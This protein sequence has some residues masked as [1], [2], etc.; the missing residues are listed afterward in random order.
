MKNL[1]SV[2]FLLRSYMESSCKNSHSVIQYYKGTDPDTQ[3]VKISNSLNSSNSVDD[4]LKE[5]LCHNSEDKLNKNDTD[6]T[7]EQDGFKGETSVTCNTDIIKTEKADIKVEP[8]SPNDSNK[9]IKIE[10]DFNSDESGFTKM[11]VDTKSEACFGDDSLKLENTFNNDVIDDKKEDLSVTTELLE[12]SS[13]E[14][15]QLTRGRK[16][17]LSS[18]TLDAEPTSATNTEE[19]EGNDESMES[20]FDGNEETDKPRKRGRKKGKKSNESIPAHLSSDMVLGYKM[21]ARFLETPQFSGFLKPAKRNIGGEGDETKIT[22]LNQIKKKF[23]DNSYKMVCEFVNDVREMLTNIYESRN[24]VAIK[25]ALRL[26]QVLE[27][28]IAQLPNYLRP[29]CALVLPPDDSNNSHNKIRI[30]KGGGFVSLLL[31]KTEKQRYEKNKEKRK[32]LAE[33]RKQLKEE[34]DKDVQEW[35]KNVLLKGFEEEIKSMWELPAIGHFIHLCADILNIGE[36]AQFEVERM[37]LMPQCSDTLDL[38]MTA[39]LTN[40][41]MRA[42]LDRTPSMP[43][44][45]WGPLVRTRVLSWYRTWHKEGRNEQ[46]LFEEIGIEPEFWRILGPDLNPLDYYYFHEISLLQRVWILKTLCDV[47]FVRKKTVH[48][49]IRVQALDELSPIYLGIDRHGN[50]YIQLKQFCASDVRIYRQSSKLEGDIT[51]S[52]YVDTFEGFEQREGPITVEKVFRDIWELKTDKQEIKTKKKK[53]TKGKKPKNWKTKVEPDSNEKKNL[54]RSV[55]EKQ[56]TYADW[57]DSDQSDTDL[58]TL[59]KKLTRSDIETLYRPFSDKEFISLSVF[60]LP[61]DKVNKPAPKK[62]IKVANRHDGHSGDKN[63][64]MDIDESKEDI[65]TQVCED[66]QSDSLDA[67]QML[68][69]QSDFEKTFHGEDINGDEFDVG[70]KMDVTDDVKFTVKNLENLKMVFKKGSTPM[71][72]TVEPDQ[73]E[74]GSSEKEVKTE[75]QEASP[76][77]KEY[78]ARYKYNVPNYLKPDS[79][80]FYLVVDSVEGLR[81]LIS[82]FG[83]HENDLEMITRGTKAKKKVAQS[84]RS[85][86]VELIEK[87]QNL[88]VELEPWEIDFMKAHRSNKEK[89][90]KEYMNFT[91]RPPDFVHPNESYWVKTCEE[92]AA[93]T[94]TSTSTTTTTTTTTTTATTDSNISGDK[95]SNTEVVAS[96]SA[97]TNQL[98]PSLEVLA[99]RR[100]TRVTRIQIQPTQDNDT[101]EDYDDADDYESNESDDNWVM[102]TSKKKAKKETTAKTP[103][104]PRRSSARK[105]KSSTIERAEPGPSTTEKTFSS[106]EKTKKALFWGPRSSDPS[107]DLNWEKNRQKILEQHNSPVKKVLIKKDDIAGDVSEAENVLQKSELS[108]VSLISASPKRLI[109]Q[110]PGNK[111]PYFS[112]VQ[113]KA[114]ENQSKQVQLKDLDGLQQKTILRVSPTVTGNLQQVEL[115]D[116]MGNITSEYLLIDGG[117]KVPV[118]IQTIGRVNNAIIKQTPVRTGQIVNRVVQQPSGKQATI[119]VVPST[120]QIRGQVQGL[121]SAKIQGVVQQKGI[122]QVQIQ[123]QE[124]SGQNRTV[125]ASSGNVRQQ[126]PIQWP[127]KVITLQAVNQQGKIVQHQLQTQV[128]VQGQSQVQLQNPTQVQ[129]GVQ[130]VIRLEPTQKWV[131]QPIQQVLGEKSGQVQQ[132]VISE[133]QTTPTTPGNAKNDL[134]ITDGKHLI[135]FDNSFVQQ[136]L[137]KEKVLTLNAN[138]KLD[139]KK[140]L[141]IVKP[142]VDSTVN[143]GQVESSGNQQNV[144]LVNKPGS[145]QQTIPTS[146]VQSIVIPANYIVKDGTQVVQPALVKSDQQQTVKIVQQAP[147][148][149][150]QQRGAPGKSPQPQIIKIITS[151]PV[152]SNQNLILSPANISGGGQV[153]RAV[154]HSGIAADQQQAKGPTTLR[155]LRPQIATPTSQSKGNQIVVNNIIQIQGQQVD[156]SKPQMV[157]GRLVSTGVPT[158]RVAPAQTQ[159][160]Q[161]ATPS[162]NVKLSGQPVKIVMSGSQP[163]TQTVIPTVTLNPQ[164]VRPT[165]VNTVRLVSNPQQQ[166]LQPTVRV[167]TSGLSQ[168]EHTK[169]LVASLSSSPEG[170]T[171]T[172]KL[173]PAGGQSLQV[174]SQT[175][176]SSPTLQQ[177]RTT[178][179]GGLA[180]VGP[181][182]TIKVV[183]N[184]L[185]PKLVRQVAPGPSTVT[186]NAAPNTPIDGQ[187]VRL[188]TVL[189]SSEVP[190]DEHSNER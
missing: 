126:H 52:E 21:L 67:K 74:E 36:V 166:G 93:S 134:Y 114:M 48:D 40:S 24:P 72:E 106:P 179:I 42:K 16:R 94:S 182:P 185:G 157:A 51:M 83:S 26:E 115:K 32:I 142:K 96:E 127:P 188:Q 28:K 33:E 148:Y 97:D 3:D 136:S 122:G 145:A 138:D 173:V 13:S 31:E 79:S 62:Y 99:P 43:Y 22:C 121:D 92:P 53:V 171:Q 55:R 15:Q 61:R 168:Q 183:A 131:Q 152:S 141:L 4:D 176:V 190:S 107:E 91:N 113:L 87:L 54:R 65:K 162:Q 147:T 102:P 66:E 132:V 17:K 128:Q 29:Q 27:Q 187:P 6:T 71:D 45:I 156:S 146:S 1:F 129:S 5:V 181:A 58:D 175:S 46:K 154:T 172:V 120:T 153:L 73:S 14:A 70:D 165:N 18:T 7:I 49:N 150:I 100:R 98:D 167:V 56:K 20:D 123:I 82:K 170:T 63:N 159:L 80:K 163:Q 180:N 116:P 186:D 78:D 135:K 8:L 149:I 178:S 184:N 117:N 161:T 118:K 144:L 174:Q 68:E 60:R 9:Q 25:R 124:P 35:E 160:V 151:Q 112:S 104:F 109:T 110:I 12:T 81:Q 10:S 133:S 57:S 130:Q 140:Q 64:K 169:T 95:G 34:Q 108:G 139:L 125:V 23:E 89:M 103:K 77:E 59:K 50:R 119:P 86:E 44:S 39:L 101:S 90:Y 164:A 19:I 158:V 11:C 69:M 85:C 88:L 37:L 75:E 76:A 105:A 143:A 38:I 111:K 189:Q 137:S 30:S 155:F 47:D 177:M 84:N 2:G 41:L